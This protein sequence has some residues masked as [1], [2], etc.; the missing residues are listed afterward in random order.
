M[1]LVHKLGWLA[2]NVVQHAAHVHTPDGSQ[3]RAG[4]SPSKVG[5]ALGAG[6]GES[7]GDGVGA[8]VGSAVGAGVGVLVHCE[9]KQELQ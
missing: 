4:F 3:L 8:S 2:R 7:V 6:V 9:L 5:A 1:Q